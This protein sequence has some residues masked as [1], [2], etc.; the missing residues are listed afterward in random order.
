M[1]RLIGRGDG[2]LGAALDDPEQGAVRI[3]QVREA[4]AAGQAGRL[5]LDRAAEGTRA[6][7]G[8]VDVGAR[9]VA[10]PVRRDL[11]AG[12]INDE[13]D[14]DTTLAAVRAL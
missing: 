12:L 10:Q 8:L 2:E 14:L 9:D 4:A 3:A 1:G 5:A 11:A 13:R 7:A 6:L